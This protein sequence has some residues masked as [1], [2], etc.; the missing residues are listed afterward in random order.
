MTVCAPPLPSHT[1][2]SFS[3]GMPRQDIHPTAREMT[4]LDVIATLL[5]RESDTSERPTAAIL[6]VFDHCLRPDIEIEFQ[7][8]FS[9]GLGRF[10]L[11]GMRCHGPLT[12]DAR[13]AF[14]CVLDW[15]K[16]CTLRRIA[17]T[18]R[19]HLDLLR[20]SLGSSTP[21]AWDDSRHPQDDDVEETEPPQAVPPAAA[22][23]LLDPPGNSCTED[24]ATLCVICRD[25]RTVVPTTETAVSEC[26]ADRNVKRKRFL[27]M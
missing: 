11:H 16:T 12:D 7:I 17:G 20:R 8:R 25:L 5:Q 19:H 2:V 10:E 22:H 15:C 3:I 1:S 4:A 26:N 21:N 23:V 18:R 6:T 9:D 14:T 13:N 24:N 27:S